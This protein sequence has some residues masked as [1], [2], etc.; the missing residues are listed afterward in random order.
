MSQVRFG[1]VG[2]GIGKA[3]ARAIAK[4]P[5]GVVAALC[6]LDVPRME[7]FAAELPE[8][9]RLFTD[10]RAMCA[11]PEIDVV[12]VGTPNQ[13]HVPVGLAAVRAG[14]H[15]LSTKPLSDSEAAARE[16]V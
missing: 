11:D 3:Q 10:Y 15:L 13:L 9:P 1:I 6:D 5:R 8:P 7:A 2:M 14:K 12:F 16:L 4:D